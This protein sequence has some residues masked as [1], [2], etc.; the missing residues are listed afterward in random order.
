[1]Y[2]HI[3]GAHQYLADGHVLITED[4]GGR[5]FEID[6]RGEIVWEFVNR[7]DEESV[8]RVSQAIRYPPGYFAV[9]D[10]TCAEA[11]AQSQDRGS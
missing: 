1:M 3:R 7:Y 6:D 8:A 10:W 11:E 2:S 5:V 9:D 4:G